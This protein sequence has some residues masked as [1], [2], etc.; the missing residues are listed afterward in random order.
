MEFN[1][2]YIVWNI[3]HEDPSPPE[4]RARTA[5]KLK[6]ACITCNSSSL[7]SISFRLQDI[8]I[9]ILSGPIPPRRVIDSLQA[10]AGI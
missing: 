7:F 5:L 6:V 2:I 8:I 1:T 4:T 3:A 9:K 10:W